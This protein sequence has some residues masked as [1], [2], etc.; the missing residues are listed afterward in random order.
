MKI[1]NNHS[2]IHCLDPA[3]RCWVPVTSLLVHGGCYSLLQHTW[4]SVSVHTCG[5]IHSHVADEEQKHEV[6]RSSTLCSQLLALSQRSAKRRPK[7]LFSP[8]GPYQRPSVP[9]IHSPFFSS[10]FRQSLRP[11][12][13]FWPRPLRP[14][15]SPPL[16]S[17]P[18]A[19]SPPQPSLPHPGGRQDGGKGADGV[20]PG[21]ADAGMDGSSNSDQ[22]HQVDIPSSSSAIDG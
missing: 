4:P 8:L 13:L 19:S 21:G 6:R 10:F 16:H 2:S 11:S 17:S 9:H 12:A 20:P 22:L 15:V 3:A 5:S 18:A 1:R 7:M 14:S